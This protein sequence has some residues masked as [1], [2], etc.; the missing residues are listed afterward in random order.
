MK[1]ETW[2]ATIALAGIAFA[3]R[4]AAVIWLGPAHPVGDMASYA[5]AAA[6]LIDTGRFSGAFLPPAYPAALAAWWGV[7]GTSVGAGAVLNACLGGLAAAAIFLAVRCLEGRR[8]ALVAAAM[9]ALGPGLIGYSTMLLSESLA[10]ALLSLALLAWTRGESQP[11]W[12]GLAGAALGLAALTRVSL[13]ALLPAVALVTAA[14][15]RWRDAAL[16]AS[17]ALLV[18]MPWTFRNISHGLPVLISTS[19]GYNLLVG[20]NPFADGSQAGGKRIFSQ[21]NPPVPEN[22]PEYERHRRGADVAMRWVAAHP[23][24]FVRKAVRGVARMFALDRQ[25]LYAAREGY[26]ASSLPKPV[27]WILA[28]L[29]VAGWPVVWVLAIVGYQLASGPTRLLGAAGLGW[30]VLA[31]AIAFGEWRFRLPLTPVWLALAG[32]GFQAMWERRLTRAIC[33]RSAAV[34]APFVVCWIAEATSR[35]VDVF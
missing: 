1:Q 13:L 3:A 4:L 31:G 2:L 28:L 9:C 34:V 24:A 25:Y 20:N 26:F 21:P 8:T 27:R 29:S 14:A 32:V 18:I 17:V 7:L 16:L 35:A 10:I 12:L 6:A 15:Y 22:L 19:T 33:G 30:L 23:V 5:R 11:A